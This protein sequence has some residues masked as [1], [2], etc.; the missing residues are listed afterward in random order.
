MAVQSGAAPPGIPVLYGGAI[1]RKQW[2]A[3]AQ[4]KK[5]RFRVVAI[6]LSTEGLRDRKAL[7]VTRTVLT[8]NF[9]R[10]ENK[11]I[12]CERRQTASSIK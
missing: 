11:A 12:D 9:G 6:F 1:V 7:L 10:Q 8:A 5:G 2:F 4:N 3:V